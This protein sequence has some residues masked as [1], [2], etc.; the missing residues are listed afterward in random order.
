MS[1][2]VFLGPSLPADAVPAGVL[3][4]PPAGQG[5]VMR[6]VRDRGATAIGLIDGVFR[7]RPAVWHKEILWALD[8][9][10]RVLGAASMGALRAAEC[11]PF[12]M[13]PVG[14]I[15]QSFVAGRFAPFDDAFQ[16]DDEVAV[17]HAP[18][19]AGFAPL[20]DALVDLRATLAAACS[21]G[22]IDAD[23]R[24]ALLGAMKAL[25]FPHRTLAALTAREPGIAVHH[26]RQ[27]ALDAQALLAALRDPAP[28]APPFAFARTLTWERFLR[29]VPVPLTLAEQRALLT[30][31][32]DPL[33]WR[34]VARAA[35]GP[36]AAA[37]DLHRFRTARDL[38]TRQALAAWCARNHADARCL[39]RLAGAEAALDAA[40]ADP[41]PG[42]LH[43]M[44]D[45][46]RL[47]DRFHLTPA[48]PPDR[49]DTLQWFLR[50][51]ADGAP[52]TPED[53]ARRLG[54]ADVNGFTR[55][56]LGWADAVPQDASP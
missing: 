9:G 2:V 53:A 33:A 20:S 30:L 28:P 47:E 19:A 21:A 25:P 14:R 5:D 27:K 13:Q 34:R 50:H 7:D 11:A 10:V 24:D 55:T 39:E 18:D 1:S 48:G 49:A 40:L 44:A 22:A 43:R 17:Q 36:G 29:G 16:D 3:A 4:L 42:L 51:M 6:A 26:V 46:L 15:A 56:V 8:R 12:G 23:R 45:L 52:M 37:P 54:F 38:F 31:A 32:L 41:P 35:L